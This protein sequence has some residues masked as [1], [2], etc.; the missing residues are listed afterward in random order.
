MGKLLNFPKM[1]YFFCEEPVLQKILVSLID[2]ENCIVDD[3]IETS[4]KDAV[5]TVIA[6]RGKKIV[7]TSILMFNGKW[8]IGI[9]TL[10][11][12]KINRKLLV[13]GE[14]YG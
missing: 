1:K 5:P 12:N 14:N 6:Y 9:E 8:K 2:N 11:L 3:D 13:R 7:L 4:D 10:I